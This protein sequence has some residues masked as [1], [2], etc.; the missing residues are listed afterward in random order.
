M[1]L[2]FH[3]KTTI[4]IS[5]FLPHMSKSVVDWCVLAPTLMM[6]SVLITIKTTSSSIDSFMCNCQKSQKSYPTSDKKRKYVKSIKHFL[7]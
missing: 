7:F 3:Q 2:A 4:P 1:L 6:A 5:K